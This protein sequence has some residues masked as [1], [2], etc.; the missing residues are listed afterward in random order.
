MILKRLIE[1]YSLESYII[2]LF[3]KNSE[4]IRVLS[5]INLN[6][7]LILDNQYFNN[8]NSE[9]ELKLLIKKIKLK[10]NDFWKKENQVNTSIKLP[11]IISVDLK[12]NEKIKKFEKIIDDLD[13][14][15]KIFYFKN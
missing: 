6:N 4:K 9:D 1:K 8:Y 13:L 10:F 5:K 11:L 2:S 7:S 3:Y 12:D 14:V 15:L